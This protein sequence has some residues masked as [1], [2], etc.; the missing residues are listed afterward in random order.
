MKHFDKVNLGLFPT[1]LYRLPNL[2]REL[3]TNVWIKRDDL[4]GVALGGNKVRKLE[5]LLH[6][7]REQG[8]DLVMTT[9]QAQ[10]NHAMLT[11]ACALRM[12]LDCI[13]IL[14]ERGIT[15]RKG[16][17][18]LNHLMGVEV[19]F[20]DTDSYDDIYAEMDRLAEEMGRKVYKIP[21][22]GSNALGSLGYIDC[23]E[24]IARSGEH[25]DHLVC[26][27]GSGGT[28]AGCVLGAKIHLPDTHVMCSMV[29]NDP[30]DVIVPQ[31]M[32]EAAELLEAD[33]EIPIPDLLDMC[34]PGYSIPSEEGNEAIA[35]MMRLEGIVLDTCYTG[36]AF[37]GLVKRAREG[38]YKPED[39]VLF[40]HTGG[41][42]GL[43][44]QDWEK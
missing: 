39:N 41:A 9:G 11:A 10:S 37:A 3:G 31:L 35:M 2:S 33:V 5:Y 13:L 24:E 36:K 14:K 25:F 19:R 44:A 4:C 38:Y 8:Y 7:A 21:C 27:C 28:A 22:G 16:N 43:F 32:R 1:P 17:Q 20:M 29:D 26:A 6:E 40:I 42:G 12:G 30:F 34:G 15:A 23:M 18:I